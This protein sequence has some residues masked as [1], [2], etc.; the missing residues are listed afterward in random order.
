MDMITLMVY[1]EVVIIACS[2][3]DLLGLSVEG[4]VGLLVGLLKN[5]ILASLQLREALASPR[6]IR[7]SHEIFT[8]LEVPKNTFK[9][10]D[11]LH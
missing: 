10:S 8:K 9:D 11:V 1:L 5:D 4:K 6:I 3:R 7:Q 2:Q